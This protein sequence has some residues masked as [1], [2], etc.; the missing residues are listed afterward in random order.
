MNKKYGWIIGALVL[1]LLAVGAFGITSAY[2]DEGGPGRPF[3]GRGGR[4]PGERTL[5]GAALEAVAGALNM[6]T[7]EVTAALESGKTLPE[8]ANEAS[9]DMQV[10]KDALSAV[11]EAN[12]RERIAQ[13][14]KDGKMSQEKANWLLE[15]L[16]KGFLDGPEFGIGRGGFDKPERP[17]ADTNS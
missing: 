2:A 6:S 10:V 4:G 12:M 16:D 7:D 17:N 11:R 3:G 9:V 8:L 15:G 5:D 14:V 13:A 1:T